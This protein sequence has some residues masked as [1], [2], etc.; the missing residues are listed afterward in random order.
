MANIAL[1]QNRDY[2]YLRY[3]K[4]LPGYANEGQGYP[5]RIL[6]RSGARR[7]SDTV[8][9]GHHNRPSMRD[10]E[11]IRMSSSTERRPKARKTLATLQADEIQKTGLHDILQEPSKRSDTRTASLSPHT[12]PQLP[13]KILVPSP[14]ALSFLSPSQRIWSNYYLRWLPEKEY[15]RLERMIGTSLFCY[16][17]IRYLTSRN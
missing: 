6:G 2:I 3:F 1:F 14:N 13:Q 8:A 5:K 12:L 16:A 10:T 15:A 7:R 11:P 17:S 9:I 4:D